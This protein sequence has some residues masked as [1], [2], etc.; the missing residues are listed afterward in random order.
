MIKQ[1]VNANSTEFY[2]LV[3]FPCLLQ[4]SNHRKNEEAPY[5][6]IDNIE[7]LYNYVHSCRKV[8]KLFVFFIKEFIAET[9]LDIFDSLLKDDSILLP[10]DKAQTQ[11]S[12]YTDVLKDFWVKRV[13]EL[14]KTRLV[15][16]EEL[17]FQAEFTQKYSRFDSEHLT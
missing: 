6:Y 12:I 2:N 11:Y 1:V 4:N 7:K 17:C 8:D 14:Y 16:I 15:K 3:I 13:K 10:F 9:P 5:L